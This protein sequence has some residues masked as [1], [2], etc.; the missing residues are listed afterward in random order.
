[1][2]S[3]AL[4]LNQWY[5]LP[6]GQAVQQRECIELLEHLINMRLFIVLQLG[7]S[8]HLQLLNLKAFNHRIIA[9]QS[10]QIAS[11]K[12][13]CRCAYHQ[14]P[15]A[16]ETIDLVIA[17]HILEFEPNATEPILAECW[18]VLAPDGYLVILTFNPWSFWRITERLLK[19]DSTLPQ[20]PHFSHR[21]DVH[22]LLLSMDAEVIISK[23]FLFQPPAST[24]SS[25]LALTWFDQFGRIIFPSAGGIN[26]L[27][28]TKKKIPLIAQKS[29][30][31]LESILSP[32]NFAEPTAGRVRRG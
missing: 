1:M 17:P 21:Q 22:S 6:L 2:N 3:T 32:K 28:A 13:M 15:F 4:T 24:Q 10:S 23:T 25:D 30:W 12:S 31:S 19:R 8:Q 11:T 29:N 5:Q 7:M 20:I 26:L 9:T 18:R 27:I 16:S 14:L